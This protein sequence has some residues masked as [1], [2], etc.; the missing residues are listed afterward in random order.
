MEITKKEI[1][2]NKLL[3]KA[4]NDY[5]TGTEYYPAHLSGEEHT[6]C[7]V[8]NPNTFHVD[9]SGDVL[10]SHGDK[11]KNGHLLSEIIYHNDIKKWAEI[12]SKPNDKDWW[13]TVAV[14]D[15]IACTE[16]KGRGG[17]GFEP[18]EVFRVRGIDKMPIHAIFFK[19]QENNVKPDGVYQDEIRKATQE[20][21]NAYKAKLGGVKPL[22]PSKGANTPGFDKLVLEARKR[23]PVGTRYVCLHNCGEGKIETEDD[24]LLRKNEDCIRTNKGTRCCWNGTHWAV[25][26]TLPDGVMARAIKQYSIGTVI[27]DPGPNKIRRAKVVRTP[28]QLPDGN[29]AGGSGYIYHEGVWAEIVKDDNLTINDLVKGEIYYHYCEN[30]KYIIKFDKLDGK[31]IIGKC[32]IS[33]NSNK[34]DPGTYRNTGVK[35][36]RVATTDEKR[37]LNACIDKGSFVSMEDALKTKPMKY[38]LGPIRFKEGVSKGCTPEYETEYGGD[39]PRDKIVHG[40]TEL[41]DEYTAEIVDYHNEYYIVRFLDS[42]SHYTQLGFLEDAL[43]PVGVGDVIKVG[44]YA[45]MTKAGGWGY[46]ERN[47]GCLAKVTEVS[48]KYVDGKNR[49]SINGEVINPR[50]KQCLKF[51]IVPQN[52]DDIG[53]V[54][55]KATQAEID[56]VVNDVSTLKKKEEYFIGSYIVWIKKPSGNAEVGDI[57]KII[58]QEDRFLH[59]KKYGSCCKSR[60]RDKEVKWFATLE[61]AQ[62]YTLRIAKDKEFVVGD[63]ITLD[64]WKRAYRIKKVLVHDYVLDCEEGDD[65]G[66]YLKKNGFRYATRNEIEGKFVPRDEITSAKTNIKSTGPDFS[67]KEEP[68]ITKGI[69]LIN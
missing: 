26:T 11:P 5:P 49:C 46:D 8:G 4:R 36:L 62:L 50:I 16:T 3:E 35:E 31:Q 14:G 53:E 1:M 51:S 34:F 58:S 56:A 54:W 52:T 29:V 38:K 32:S 21:I 22:S 17:L 25:I 12:K 23:Y 63:W 43:E 64:G 60:I 68:E 44:D 7:T 39:I 6:L 42:N 20:E 13:K 30:Y 2:T 57:D 15:I 48:T 59:L 28:K 61:E 66:T 67:L 33:L 55:R 9:S 10:E 24:F 47:N 69:D 37:W 45:I 40:T 27:N 19:V 41:H 18:N 65:I